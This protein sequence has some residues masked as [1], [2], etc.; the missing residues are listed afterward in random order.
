MN[1]LGFEARWRDTLFAAMIPP[2]GGRPGL[3]DMELSGFWNEVGEAAPPLARIGLRVAVWLL[4]LLP[5][6]TP[7]FFRTFS[8]LDADGRDRFLARISSSKWYILRQLLMT[9][10]AFSAFAYFRD[11]N[12]RGF[13]PMQIP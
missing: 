5:L 8:G 2:S 10:K 3:G 1:W 7:G 13:F 4:N 11:G 9:I 12:V 6:V